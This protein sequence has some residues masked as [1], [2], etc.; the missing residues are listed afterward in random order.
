MIQERGLPHNCAA[1]WSEITKRAGQ[2]QSVA[3]HSPTVDIHA[4]RRLFTT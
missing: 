4:T 1:E 2:N 3:N